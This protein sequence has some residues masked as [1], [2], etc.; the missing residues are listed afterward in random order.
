MAD[1]V[2]AEPDPAPPGELETDP[3]RL[4]NGL[5]D[6]GGEVGGL[7]DDERDPGPPGEGR[8]PPETL[9]EGTAG[10]GARGGRDLRV[11]PDRAQ[12]EV[13]HEEIDRPPRQ[14]RAG[15][16]D[17]LVG[18]SRS[19]HD[20]PLEVDAPGDGLDRVESGG[21]VQPG[22]DRACRL[23]LGDEPEGDR[24]PPARQVS[25]EREAD[26]LRQPAG[27][28][29]RVEGPEAGRDDPILVA[30]GTCVGHED[31]DGGERADDGRRGRAPPRP[32]G[33]ESGRDVR[34]ERCH[35]AQY[36]TDVRTNQWVPRGV[37][38]AARATLSPRPTTSLATDVPVGM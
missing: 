34:G 37:A 14:E 9:G 13:D 11:R 27:T 32:E 10:S 33:R 38:A 4:A 19:H 36:R 17:S 16:R 3:R 7:E 25:A 2:A 24:R 21:Q 23:R 29:D 18:R 26:S 12:R 1:D 30:L 28:E 8:Q 15:D 35:E 5:G 31:R 22:D 6:A 20:E